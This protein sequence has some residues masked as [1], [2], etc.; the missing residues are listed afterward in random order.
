MT[1]LGADQLETSGLFYRSRYI[2]QGAPH[3]ILGI[4]PEKY[5]ASQLW[6]SAPDQLVSHSLPIPI[7]IPQ[8]SD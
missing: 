5:K 2:Q 4:E 3:Q 6:A 8:N 1:N 7:P